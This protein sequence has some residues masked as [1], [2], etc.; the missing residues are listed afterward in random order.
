MFTHQEIQRYSK[1]LILDDIG[2]E[3]QQKLKAAKVLVVG[4]GGLG[5]PVLQYLNAV[6]VGTL[7]I[8][9]F[10]VVDAGNLHRQILYGPQDVGCKK[11]TQA[12]KRLAAQNPFTTLIA[13]ELKVDER[14]AALLIE[15]YDFVVD[16]CDNFATRYA[17]NDACVALGKPLIYGS[18]LG[19]QGQVAVFNHNGSK[20][21]RDVFPEPPSAEDVPDCAENG[22]LGTVPGIIGIIM[23]QAAVNVILQRASFEN[24][25]V[26]FDTLTMERAVLNL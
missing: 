19:Y 25:L 20:H 3:G 22:V 2:L 5:C 8:A 12:M 4:A 11:V 6:G 14:N 15:E 21:L 17:V 1:Q 24:Q 7:G 10:D 18:I 13:H 26:L 9:E 16:G 23:A